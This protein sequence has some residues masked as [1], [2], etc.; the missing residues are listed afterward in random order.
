M[1]GFL[2]SLF[3]KG[4][5]HVGLNLAALVPNPPA[6][7]ILKRFPKY[8]LGCTL[9]IREYVG[10]VD[11]IYAD[12]N[13]ALMCGAVTHG[14]FEAQEDPPSSRDQIFYSIIVVRRSGDNQMGVLLA[15]GA[16]L[17]G[18]DDVELEGH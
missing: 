1:F 15:T 12:Y 13:A 18:E 10:I 9:R 11:A 3:G 17:A 5:K 2:W 8:P 16:V 4:K 6:P 7:C 14:W